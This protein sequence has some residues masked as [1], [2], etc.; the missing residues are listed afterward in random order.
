MAGLGRPPKLASLRQRSNKVST[1][2]TLESPEKAAKRKV[3]PL[4][5]RDS[6][7]ENWHPKVVE[8]WESVWKSPMAAEYLGPDMVGGLY[9]LAELYQRRWT[10]HD[11]K[12]LVS[13]AAEIRLQEVRFGLS[14]I[15]RRRLQWEVEKGEEAAERTQQRRKAKKVKR[16]AKK[17]P[18]EVLKVI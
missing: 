2:A 10:C 18:R 5:K 17:D 8:W 1:R 16:A 3:P 7:A 15:D 14:P 6:E 12:V 13:L 9:T 11:S 4:P